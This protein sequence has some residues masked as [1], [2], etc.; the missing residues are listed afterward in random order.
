MML[1]NL[2]LM[3]QTLGLGGFPNFAEHEFSWFQALGFRM[4]EMPAGKYLGANLLARF[5]MN[6][7]GANHA[8]PYSLGL[9]RDGKILLAPYSPP[10]YATMENA[11]HAVVEAKFGPQ[12]LFRGGA[13]RSAWREPAAIANGVKQISHEA[14]AATHIANTFT[15][16]M[17]AFLPTFRPS[18]RCWVFKLAISTRSF[19]TATTG[20]KRYQKPSAIIWRIGTAKSRHEA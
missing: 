6:V 10:Y 9:E 1:Q 18:V 4:E 8:I 13:A 5:L 14:V 17:D 2:A 19:T 7:F 15:S 20:P 16:V 3:C 12:G 11:V